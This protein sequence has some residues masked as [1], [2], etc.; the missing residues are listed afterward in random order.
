M[1]VTCN[2]IDNKNYISIERTG[3]RL[4]VYWIYAFKEII[5]TKSYDDLSS[6]EKYIQIH[7]W[8]IYMFHGIRTY[9]AILGNV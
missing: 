5:C 3:P 9:N 2:V 1:V 8:F 7:V 4:V 6:G